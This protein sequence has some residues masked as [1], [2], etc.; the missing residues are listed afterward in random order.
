M[1]K[2][3]IKKIILDSAKLNKIIERM[4]GEII[5]RNEDIENI[6]LVGL[7]TRGV[8]LAKRISHIINKIE[9]I[10]VPVGILDISLYRDDFATNTEM[11][12]K[13]TD[14]PFSVDDKKIIIIDDV[15][16]TGRSV[17]AAIECIMDFGRPKLIRLAVLID[18]GH[19][20]L[21]IRADFVG[22]KFVTIPDKERISVKLA[23]VDEL[24]QVLLLDKEI[25]CSSN[26]V[27]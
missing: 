2:Y 4:A 20:E 22:R 14:F 10:Q 3:K 11:L 12:L 8:F 27:F 6:A 21:P 19:R 26:L 25:N 1:G 7:Q 5:E 17:R 9:N 18:R 23:E 13:Q 16:Y 15:L 24:D